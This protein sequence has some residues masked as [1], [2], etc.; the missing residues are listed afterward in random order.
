L[1]GRKGICPVRYCAIVSLENG[2]YFRRRKRIYFP[3]QY[4]TN[5]IRNNNNNNNG[6]FV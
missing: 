6:K 2:C 3:K 1:G 5:N 4:E